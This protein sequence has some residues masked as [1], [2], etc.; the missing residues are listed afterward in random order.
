[1]NLTVTLFSECTSCGIWLEVNLNMF[2]MIWT[3]CILSMTTSYCEI[4]SHS[5]H[6]SILGVHR[7]EYALH[8]GYNS[9]LVLACQHN[10]DLIIS[11]LHNLG[12]N[13]ASGPVRGSWTQMLILSWH[14]IHLH[15]YY[16]HS[17][18]WIARDCNSLGQLSLNMNQVVTC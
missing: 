6:V 18:T 4:T 1:M 15:S 14:I 8:V 12:T 2:L 9:Y 13:L 3:V 11:P 17:Q 7:F 10:L 16:P 5:C